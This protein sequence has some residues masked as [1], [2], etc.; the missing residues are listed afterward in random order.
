MQAWLMVVCKAEFSMRPSANELILAVT[1][2][3][4]WKMGEYG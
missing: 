4:N 3:G 1:S 2:K